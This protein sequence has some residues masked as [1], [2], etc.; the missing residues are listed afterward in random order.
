MSVGIKMEKVIK[1]DMVGP[2]CPKVNMLV[3][4]L[5][6]GEMVVQDW[7]KERH[8]KG[9]QDNDDD[10]PM[11]KHCCRGRIWQLCITLWA[12]SLALLSGDYPGF[13]IWSDFKPLAVPEAASPKPATL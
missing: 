4:M 3:I 12:H 8:E 7:P 11:T 13:P 9:I 10:K 2:C 6:L 1:V 5:P